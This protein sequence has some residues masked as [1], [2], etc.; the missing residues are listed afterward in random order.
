MVA[1]LSGN[2]PPPAQRDVNGALWIT[3]LR[4]R[5]VLERRLVP[6][7]FDAVEAALLIVSGRPQLRPGD[8]LTVRAELEMSEPL[9]VS[10]M[11]SREAKGQAAG[12]LNGDSSVP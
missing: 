1:R 12:A 8:T 6:N 10:E 3:L 2:L 5:D 7:G 4:G 11:R 9:P